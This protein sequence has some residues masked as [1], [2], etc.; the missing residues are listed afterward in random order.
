MRALNISVFV[1]CLIG[2]LYYT[3][4]NNEAQGCRGRFVGYPVFHRHATRP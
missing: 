2:G 1:I 3:A 4:A